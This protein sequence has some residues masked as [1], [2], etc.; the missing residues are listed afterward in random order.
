MNHNK[1]PGVKSGNT[2]ANRETGTR[3][4][5]AVLVSVWDTTFYAFLN[6]ILRNKAQAEM[7]QKK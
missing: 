2:T 5:R 1:K 3:K 4:E 7:I 6:V